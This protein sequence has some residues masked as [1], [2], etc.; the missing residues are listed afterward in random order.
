M[1]SLS[2]IETELR[3]KNAKN[4]TLLAGCLF[5]SEL[6]I[7]S[8]ISIMRSPTV[9]DILPEGGDSRR[10]LMMV[11]ALAALGC[12]VL[13]IYSASVFLSYKSR[14]A[15]I[16]MLLGSPKKLISGQLFRELGF[17][18][19]VSCLA[20]TL[21][22]QPFSWC[23]W[24]LFRMFVVDTKE[25][26]LHFDAK[27]YLGSLVFAFF[28]FL[29]L[30]VMGVSFV[31]RTNII[32][33]V[34]QQHISE[35]IRDVKAWYGPLGII[36][37]ITG[38]FA[39]YIAP[40]VSRAVFHRYAHGWSNLFYLPLFIGLYM[41][42]VY[43]V[44]RGWKKGRER[45]K[46]IVSRSMMKFQGR[47][48][49]NNMLVIAIL[50]VGM[51][52]AAFYIPIMASGTAE[53]TADRP[54]DYAFHYRVDNKN[55]LTQTDI[56]NMAKNENVEITSFRETEFAVLGHDG[57]EEISDGG[58][59]FHE[60]YQKLLSSG[61]YF[62][63]SAF[64]KMT[65]QNI[66]I[67]KGAFAE[68]IADE[69][70]GS[71]GSDK[72]QL[73]TNIT[74]RKTFTVGFQQYLRF[75]MLAS[76]YNAANYV[77]DD[78]DYA[79]IVSGIDD[80]WMER[81]VYFNVKNDME[82]YDFAKQLYYNI[83]SSSN[84]ECGVDN[85]YDFVS[86]ISCEERGEKYYGD[87]YKVDYSQPDSMKFRLN[88][89]YMPQFR[90]I[91]KNDFIK[92]NSVFLMVFAFVAIVCFA[93]VLIIGYIRSIA[94]SMNNRYVYGDLRH[95]GASPKYPPDRIPPQISP[96]DCERAAVKDFRCSCF[97][98]NHAYFCILYYDF[99]L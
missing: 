58:G 19:L 82:T 81:L 26:V 99:I 21:L 33:I 44:V 18:A 78:L 69:A 79:E 88:W 23:V 91:D 96:Q 25:M 46:N 73:L 59:R 4:Y 15:G 40:A 83:I 65:G 97:H 42:L 84:P 1:K 56:E 30:A 24:E 70:K 51:Y 85:S 98:W 72:K 14:E 64:N 32:D 27:A 53:G 5:F 37:I 55:M 35:P 74:T 48:T 20:G 41:V 12:G 47:Q 28:I 68:I 62:S 45:Y 8:Y 34:N 2:D 31:K 87:E 9:L 60:N 76:S 13:T 89:K 86:K 54:V 36:L 80:M 95:L 29:A 92:E 77:L 43:T 94:I 90:V 38:G 61:N 7:T 3:R 22:G 11:F 52:F 17:V 75:N 71:I 10:L 63:E 57:N 6:L 50:I 39:G 49:V 66:N 16:F 67:K 93:A